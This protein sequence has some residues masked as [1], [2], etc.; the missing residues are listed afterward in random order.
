MKNKG[1]VASSVAAFTTLAILVFYN[2]TGGGLLGTTV[3]SRIIAVAST[4]GMAYLLYGYFFKD[5]R[6]LKW[7]LLS[8]AII[9]STRSVFIGLLRGWSDVFI[10]TGFCLALFALAA[11]LREGAE[12]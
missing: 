7:G 10:W 12:N 4:F 1:L 3:G 8:T 5:V 6:A 2:V 11:Y 9:F